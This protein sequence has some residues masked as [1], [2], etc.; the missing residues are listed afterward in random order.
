MELILGSMKRVD[1]AL[2][3]LVG[4]VLLTEIL[5][6]FVAASLWVPVFFTAWIVC[7]D[8]LDSFFRGLM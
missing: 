5:K 2:E 6:F 7:F 1:D 8:F 3:V 4:S